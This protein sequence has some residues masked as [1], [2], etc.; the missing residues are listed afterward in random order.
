ILSHPDLRSLQT[1]IGSAFSNWINAHDLRLMA[2]ENPRQTNPVDHRALELQAE[3]LVEDSIAA[4]QAFMDDRQQLVA[5]WVREFEVSSADGGGTAWLCMQ[6]LEQ[7]TA[8]VLECIAALDDA[9]RQL[10]LI[11]QRAGYVFARTV[12]ATRPPPVNNHG[13]NS[14]SILQHQH[15]RLRREY[16]KQVAASWGGICEYEVRGFAAI[17]CGLVRD[18][19]MEWS[20][21]WHEWIEECAQF[22]VGRCCHQI[23]A[24]LQ[25]THRPDNDDRGLDG[26]HAREGTAGENSATVDPADEIGQRVIFLATHLEAFLEKNMILPRDNADVETWISCRI[27]LQSRL[28]EV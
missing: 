19:V 8:D 28:K 17:H 3:E 15:V 23:R 10:E 4:A 13:D 11:E 16:Y 25:E 22:L 20:A 5:Q 1:V 18:G 21:K 6:R 12:C 7:G 2:N 9:L 24:C 27:R 26:S 14:G